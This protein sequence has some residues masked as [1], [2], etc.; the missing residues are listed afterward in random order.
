MISLETAT[1]NPCI[2]GRKKKSFYGSN[3][4]NPKPP[5]YAFPRASSVIFFMCVL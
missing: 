2:G 3:D 5:Q 4:D 1:E